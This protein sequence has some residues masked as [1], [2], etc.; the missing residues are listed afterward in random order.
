MLRERMDASRSQTLEAGGIPAEHHGAIAKVMDNLIKEIKEESRKGIRFL[1]EKIDV[2]RAQDEKLEETILKA[3][4]CTD[5]I[6]KELKEIKEAQRLFLKTVDEKLA[7][8][9]ASMEEYNAGC[10]NALTQCREIEKNFR[11]RYNDCSASAS[12]QNSSSNPLEIQQ[13]GDSTAGDGAYISGEKRNHER[14]CTLEEKMVQIIPRLSQAEKTVHRLSRDSR[15][16]SVER[17]NLATNLSRRARERSA[18]PASD[19]QV[20]RDAAHLLRGTTPRGQREI[21]EHLQGIAFGD[22]LAND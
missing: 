7:I 13:D 15:S 8:G 22:C 17:H 9:A 6:G 21:E 4:L 14:L 10:C 20:A 11:R 5:E 18:E 12:S 1:Q 19:I 16:A 2:L 3:R